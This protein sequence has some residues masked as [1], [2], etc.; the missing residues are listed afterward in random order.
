MN[1][2]KRKLSYSRDQGINCLIE[3]ISS[4]PI[5]VANVGRGAVGALV[6]Q[7]LPETESWQRLQTRSPVSLFGHAP[8][9]LKALMSAKEDRDREMWLHNDLE[10]QAIA[11]L[12]GK[13]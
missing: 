11:V 13:G 1:T 6:P 7:L 9:G 10:R 3:F 8:I 2:W 4:Y 5:A 12:K